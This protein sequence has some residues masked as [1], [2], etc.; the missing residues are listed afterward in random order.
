MAETL[1]QVKDL[2]EKFTFTE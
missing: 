2:I 1:R